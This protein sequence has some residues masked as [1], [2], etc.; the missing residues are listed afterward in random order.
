MYKLYTFFSN[1]YLINFWILK[2]FS[3]VKPGKTDELTIL[4]AFKMILILVF[5]DFWFLKNLK[6]LEFRNCQKFFLDSFLCS[7]NNKFVVFSWFYIQKVVQLTD[8]PIF[9]FFGK[10][11]VNSKMSVNF[12]FS[13]ISYFWSKN[14]CYLDFLAMKNFL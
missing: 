3:Y 11:S 13:K 8:T 2:S 14:C 10:V 1:I 4:R 6:N 12:R 7:K 5:N 9:A